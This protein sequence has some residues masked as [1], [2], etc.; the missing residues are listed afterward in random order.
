MNDD[1]LPDDILTDEIEEPKQ[2]SEPE[3]ETETQEGRPGWLRS[4]L[5]AVRDWATWDKLIA[6]GVVILVLHFLWYNRDPMTIDFWGWTVTAP[7]ILGLIIVFLLGIVVGIKWQQG[8][9]AGKGVVDALRKR[10]EKGD[11]EK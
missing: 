6:I 8:W 7:K 4:R 11:E 5:A 1:F 10:N 9:L 2:D 3:P